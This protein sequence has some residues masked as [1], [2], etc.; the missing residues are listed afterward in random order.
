MHKGTK[1]SRGTGLQEGRASSSWWLD[2]EEWLGSNEGPRRPRSEDMNT[3]VMKRSSGPRNASHAALGSSEVHRRFLEEA[4]APADARA[5][6]LTEFNLFLGMGPGPQEVL[7]PKWLPCDQGWKPKKMTKKW[8]CGE[9]RTK[10]DKK[11]SATAVLT[12]GRG[13]SPNTGRGSSK[14]KCWFGSKFLRQN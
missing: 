9:A 12:R 4:S 1:S 11:G 14:R 13:G 2:R 5:L 8:D 7:V 10:K 3:G 6:T